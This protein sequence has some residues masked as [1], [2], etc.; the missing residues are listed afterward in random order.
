M[1]EDLTIDPDAGFDYNY[2][3]DKEVTHSFMRW[4]RNKISID[5][6]CDCGAKSEFED[7]FMGELDCWNCGETWELPHTIFPRKT[8]RENPMPRE[9]PR[10]YGQFWKDEQ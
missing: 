5:F 7:F 1:R 2:A 9:L 6:F 10:G 4:D 3:I 8:Q